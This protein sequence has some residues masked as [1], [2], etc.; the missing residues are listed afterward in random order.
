[1]AVTVND[2]SSLGP[3]LSNI[4]N[5]FAN[6]GSMAVEADQMRQKRALLIAQTADE[7]EAAKLKQQQWDILHGGQGDLAALKAMYAQEGFDPG[8]PDVIGKI[9]S[10]GMSQNPQTG[11]LSMM[12]P[13]DMY[14]ANIQLK[15]DLYAGGADPFSNTLAAVNEMAWGGTPAGAAADNTAAYQ[16]ELD[17]QALVNKGDMAE[18]LINKAIPDPTKPGSGTSSTTQA[19][20]D[21]L[22]KTVTDYFSSTYPGVAVTPEVTNAVLAELGPEA[23]ARGIVGAVQRVAARMGIGTRNR[24]GGFLGIGGGNELFIDP[25]VPKSAAPAGAVGSEVAAKLLEAMG[26]DMS[27]MLRPGGG[28]G[29]PAAPGLDP[30]APPSLGPRRDLAPAQGA[31]PASPAAPDPS[32]AARPMQ[33]K[34]GRWWVNAPNG[35][36]VELRDNTMLKGDPRKGMPDWVWKN[37][38][39]NKME[40]A[41]PAGA[42]A[43]STPPSRD[44]LAAANQKKDEGAAAPVRQAA[45]PKPQPKEVITE[46]APDAPAVHKGRSGTYSSTD[47]Q[48]KTIYPKDGDIYRPE[49]PAGQ[50]NL[51]FKSGKWTATNNKGGG[52][53]KSG[54]GPAGYSTP[55]RERGGGLFTTGPDGKR[56]QLKEGLKIDGWI[57][58]NGK[59]QQEA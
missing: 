48:G 10:L 12:D 26:I 45:G 46:S 39:W 59:W 56:V 16:R 55:Q 57:F 8:D 28:G 11:G 31:A 41:A 49:L 43:P 36:V 15:P 6:S 2:F 14:K 40:A 44:E 24:P 13:K 18:L 9:I 7:Q 47:P 30:N 32:V 20:Y 19:E 37:G 25:T 3:A 51:V 34:E 50:P 5:L 17:K 21:I 22:T 27:P 33:D 4:G 38:K 53:A 58:T 52:A 1:M 42:A 23:D 54:T 35:E 29:A